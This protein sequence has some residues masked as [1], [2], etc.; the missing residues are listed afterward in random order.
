MMDIVD[1]QVKTIYLFGLHFLE[2]ATNTNVD[3]TILIFDAVG[4]QALCP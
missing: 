4:I 3:I 2:K 1:L